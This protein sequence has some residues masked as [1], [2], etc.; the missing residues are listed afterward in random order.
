MQLEFDLTSAVDQAL[1]ESPVL[2]VVD[3]EARVEQSRYVKGRGRG[4][5]RVYFFIKDENMLDNLF[6]RHFRPHKEYRKL[7]PEVLAKAGIVTNEPIRWS[8]KAGCSCPCSPGF[9]LGDS[10]GKTVYVTITGGRKQ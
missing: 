6:D 3:V 1:K 2:T 9:I 5:T 8:Q 4:K 10:Y 7:L